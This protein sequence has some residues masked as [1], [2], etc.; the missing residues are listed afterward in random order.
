MVL[1]NIKI[2]KLSIFI[3]DLFKHED[4]FIYILFFLNIQTNL[5]FSLE[6]YFS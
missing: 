1:Y 5:E 2:L 4:Y 3:V 6:I